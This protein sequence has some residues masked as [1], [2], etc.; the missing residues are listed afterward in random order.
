MVAEK[1]Y[2]TQ[3]QAGLGMIP[4]TL[5]LLRRWEPGMLPQALAERVIAEGV[6]ARV[7]ARRSRNLAAEMFAPRYLS[8]GGEPAKRIRRLLDR[9]LPHDA[10]VQLFFL[11]T[12]RAQQILR[13]FIVE[14]YWS[15]YAAAA[16]SVTKS[17]AEGFIHRA[18]DMGRMGKRWSA[19][20]IHRVSGYLLGCCTDFGLLGPG[21]ASRPIRRF[22]IR[23]EV[24]LYLTHDLHFSGFSDR[25]LISHEDWRL[26]GLEPDDTLRLV[27]NLSHDGHLLVQSGAD[28]VQISWKYRTMEECI[29][30]LAKG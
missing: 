27:S 9:R 11:Q 24:V 4:E 3:L 13:D 22:A 28:L 14:I 2:T 18:L 23:P 20:T 16:S 25:N 29:H 21:V 15:K 1:Q 17:D 7:T 8:Q 10:I 12:A 6:F 5:E 19:S 26:F 30:A